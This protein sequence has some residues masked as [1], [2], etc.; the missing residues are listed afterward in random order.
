MPCIAVSGNPITEDKV[1]PY[2]KLVLICL[3]TVTVYPGATHASEFGTPD[4]AR[5]MLQSAVTALQT[6]KSAALE[7]FSDKHGGYQDRDLYIFC[8][9][10]DGNLTAHARPNSVGLPLRSFIDISGKP[11]GEEM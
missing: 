5:V 4:E 6:D 10:P 11:V 8:G 1:M 2:L 7:A 3:F 9:G